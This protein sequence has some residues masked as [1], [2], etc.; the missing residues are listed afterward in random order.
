VGL[1]TFPANLLAGAAG[2]KA[3]E[4][5]KVSPADAADAPVKF[6]GVSG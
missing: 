5:F 4:L 3:R 1:E 6:G 2:F